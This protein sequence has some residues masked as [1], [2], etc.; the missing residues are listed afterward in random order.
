M[1]AN[2]A[3]AELF[4]FDQPVSA[5]RLALLPRV[6]YGLLAADLWIDMVPHA[7]RYGVDGF[8]VA[9]FA[10]LD[11]LVPQP[12]A[13]LYTA[14]L[15]GSGVLAASCA[16]GPAV[17][18]LRGVLCGAYTLAW[19]LSMHD[20]YQHHYLLSWLLLALTLF[21]TRSSARGTELVGA[22]GYVLFS[23]S[24]ANVYAF[25]AVSKLA[26]GWRDGSVL[27]LLSHSRP[28]G[29]PSRGPLDGLRD[30]ASAVGIGD[31]LFF[32]GLAL[33]T[34][35]MQ[36]AIAVG[37]L[38]SIGADTPYMRWPRRAARWLA[39][40]A[41]LA[42]H[43]SAELSGVFSIGWFS[44]Y[45]ALVAGA[46]LAPAPALWRATERAAQ[47]LRRIPRQPFVER[48]ALPLAAAAWVAAVA[49]AHT[50]HIPGLALG[51]LCGAVACGA[52]SWPRATRGGELPA[53]AAA[54]G[55]FACFQLSSAAFDYHRRLAGELL[56]LGRR[57]DALE[58]YREAERVAPRGESRQ[59]KIRALEATPDP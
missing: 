2:P 14:L 37:Y 1:P 27:R 40:A 54:I 5:V 6:L 22:P 46:C 28:A 9:H 13:A 34:A 29:D 56:K 8:N 15:A 49:W 17:R 18:A 3:R 39:L 57:A 24:C 44:V 19:A 26:P 35:A 16:L 36:V 47:A 21:P 53:L 11:R 38:A 32:H 7:G 12:G 58:A 25:T 31:G 59:G 30:A 10:W 48:H 42:F 20:S 55:F 50:L 51:A 41:A 33:A 45:M 43:G 4:P 23:I 52:A